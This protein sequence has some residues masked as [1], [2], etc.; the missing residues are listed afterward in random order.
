M[1]LQLTKSL[2]TNLDKTKIFSG[3]ADG[4]ASSSALRWKH[5]HYIQHGTVLKAIYELLNPISETNYQNVSKTNV[6]HEFKCGIVPD[7][8]V[9]V[10]NKYLLDKYGRGNWHSNK[11]LVLGHTTCR[12][13]AK[14]LRGHKMKVIR[15][16]GC[17]RLAHKQHPQV[18]RVEG[19]SACKV[20]R[21]CNRVWGTLQATSINNWLLWALLWG[22]FWCLNSFIAKT[23]VMVGL[24]ENRYTK[25][26]L[27]C[28]SRCICHP[29]FPLST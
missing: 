6:T 15:K 28:Q 17:S 19:S 3:S 21:R 14:I 2:V 7:I 18:N 4:S 20:M 23:H 13:L 25:D 27:K 11:W 8:F 1:L 29:L 12:H 24:W 22:P 16:Q 26:W 9:E 10:L 5:K